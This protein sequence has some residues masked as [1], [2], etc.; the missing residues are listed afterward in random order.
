MPARIHNRLSIPSVHGDRHNVTPTERTDNMLQYGYKKIADA[1][2]TVGANQWWDESN[3]PGYFQ[4]GNIERYYRT[5]LA[6]SDY[7]Q[8]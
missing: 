8:D 4:R 5:K 7:D 6:P 3:E 2:D 1:Q